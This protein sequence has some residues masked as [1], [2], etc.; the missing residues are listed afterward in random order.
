MLICIVSSRLT[1]RITALVTQ[2]YW[3]A[4][5]CFKATYYMMLSGKKHGQGHLSEGQ[6][7]WW[8]GGC[9][10][11]SSFCSNDGHFHLVFEEELY[12]PCSMIEYS[13]SNA[14]CSLVVFISVDNQCSTPV[15]SLDFLGQHLEV[16]SMAAYCI[17]CNCAWLLSFQH[18]HGNM[19][20]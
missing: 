17:T 16:S 7:L 13:Y 4:N 18:F 10:E 12:F 20:R 3:L 19:M 14:V 11:D 2:S 15:V 8:R 5:T 9:V 6:A 1:R